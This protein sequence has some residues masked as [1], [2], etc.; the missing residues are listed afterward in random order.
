MELEITT[1]VD[2]NLPSKMS[3]IFA[4]FLYYLNRLDE[5]KDSKILEVLKKNSRIWNQ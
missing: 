4:E 5:I 2:K 3:N 1:I